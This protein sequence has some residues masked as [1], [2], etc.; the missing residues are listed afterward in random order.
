MVYYN[1]TPIA[2][3]QIQLLNDKTWDGQVMQNLT[4]DADGMATFSLN[5]TLFNG[6]DIKLRVC[7]YTWR[8]CGQVNRPSV[9]NNEHSDPPCVQSGL[10]AAGIGTSLSET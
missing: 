9:K 7:G 1:D 2:D 8:L 3:K 10:S 4:T 5:T 6:E